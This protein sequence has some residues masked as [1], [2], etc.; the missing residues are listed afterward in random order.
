[1][2]L[3]QLSAAD[4]RLVEEVERGFARELQSYE[5]RHEA[6]A[7]ALIGQVEQLQGLLADQIRAFAAER[8][9]RIE[10]TERLAVSTTQLQSLQ[11]EQGL[12]GPLKAQLQRAEAQLADVHDEQTRQ[13]SAQRDMFED[14]SR[15]LVVRRE[16]QAEL[17]DLKF[18][19]SESELAVMQ[20][21]VQSSE[22]HEQIA[23]TGILR[24]EMR[25][26]KHQVLE[27]SERER[28]LKN[29]VTQLKS[30]FH[31]ALQEVDS[32]RNEASNA[33]CHTAFQTAELHQYRQEAAER[34]AALTAALET[35][36]HT[37]ER[38]ARELYECRSV[39][40]REVAD[41]LAS[42][43]RRRMNASTT[44]AS[45]EQW[46]G[47]VRIAD[48]LV[49]SEHRSLLRLL[50]EDGVSRPSAA[51]IGTGVGDLLAALWEERRSHDNMSGVVIDESHVRALVQSLRKLTSR[52]QRLATAS[53]LHLATAAPGA[54]GSA[55]TAATA[56]EGGF[57]R[58]DVP[59]AVS[60]A[61]RPGPIRSLKTRGIGAVQDSGGINAAGG[62]TVVA[63]GLRKDISALESAISEAQHIVGDVEALLPSIRKGGVE[64]LNPH[65][66]ESC[67]SPRLSSVC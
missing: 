16:V 66:Q 45:D 31:A 21:R 2:A 67:L 46:Q 53:R 55:V 65:R 40:E 56:T 49:A 63:A 28:D 1:M 39:V 35:L 5:A 24:A 29:D 14:K 10:A 15:Q 7:E 30:S 9:H 6:D 60:A 8:Q 41:E 48:R 19:L 57:H 20:G 23:D 3:G 26:L 54:G 62:R 36:R 13:L 34:G 33:S 4:L 47:Q 25:D 59:Q 37:D 51:L 50:Q 32:S 64:E 43:L 11:A 38:H 58:R 52:S 17:C 18:Q 61:P 44:D 42:V 27:G 22:V 12:I